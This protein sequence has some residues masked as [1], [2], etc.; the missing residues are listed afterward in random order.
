MAKPV[1]LLA[2]EVARP[3]PG[4]PSKRELG[5]AAVVVVVVAEDRA[6]RARPHAG[7]VAGDEDHG[8]AAGAGR[9]SGSVLPITMKISRVGV[10]RAGDPPL[11]AVDDV[12][13][14]VALDA[15]GDVGGVGGGDVGLGHRERR[16]DLGRR[17]AARA[18][19]PSARRC[20]TC[21]STS[22]L[23]VSGAAQFSA[24]GREV[25][26]AA[27]DLGE[28]R[29]LQVG[30]PGAVAARRAGRGST[31]RARGP[32]RAAPAAPG[33]VVQAHGS[34]SA[35]QLLVRRPARPGRRAS[36]MKS[37]SSARAAPRCGRRV[38]SPSVVLLQSIA[39]RPAASERARP[40]RR[41]VSK[42]SPTVWPW[43]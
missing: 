24:A 2:D 39:V 34:S 10:H 38:R 16:A 19:A 18:S 29:V 36:S 21:A 42:P 41:S 15:G 6:C 9:P 40:R 8:T 1:A 30:Q 25:A 13:V 33:R 28:R 31:A 7:G 27:G 22:M 17:A 32:R 11:A 3:A 12:L 37:S 5:V 43:G 23:P 26:A 35:A 14:A 4:R 20:R